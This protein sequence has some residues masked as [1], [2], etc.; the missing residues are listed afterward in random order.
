MFKLGNK[1][2][3]QLEHQNP[4]LAKLRDQESTIF[5]MAAAGICTKM[6]LVLIKFKIPKTMNAE[7]IKDRVT[8][9]RLSKS[10]TLAFTRASMSQWVKLVSRK[11]QMRHNIR[12]KKKLL[13]KSFKDSIKSKL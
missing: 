5:S 2:A 8:S 10:L 9:A 13:L 6:W 12:Q 4:S 3:D 1:L 7:H 11:G